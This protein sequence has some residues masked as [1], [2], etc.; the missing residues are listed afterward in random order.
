MLICRLIINISSLIGAPVRSWMCFFCEKMRFRLKR[1]LIVAH[2]HEAQVKD[3]IEN[4]SRARKITENIRNQG[5][6]EYNLKNAKELGITTNN[7]KGRGN[8]ITCSSCKSVIKK[9]SV[10]SHKK[11]CP[12]SCPLPINDELI[13]CD[14]KFKSEVFDL[15]QK[16]RTGNVKSTIESEV[17][18]QFLLHRLYL[19]KKK[20]SSHYDTR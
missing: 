16:F 20:V 10:R 1:H 17:D 3:M 8:L 15:M 5:L 14:S 6:F 9:T 11:K 19:K 18:L 12:A 13:A 7:I 2:P 4:P